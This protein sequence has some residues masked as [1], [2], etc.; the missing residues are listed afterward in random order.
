MENDGKI[1]SSF[2]TSINET[3]RLCLVNGMAKKAEKFK[4]D[5]KVPDKR[6]ILDRTLSSNR[7]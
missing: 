4:S 3:I 7:V 5:F 1:V 6:Y 2:G